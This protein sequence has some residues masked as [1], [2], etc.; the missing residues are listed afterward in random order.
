MSFYKYLKFKQ[1]ALFALSDSMPLTF[2]VAISMLAY[3]YGV[4]SQEDYFS[5]IIASMIDGLFL[6]ILIRKLYKWFDLKNIKS[7]KE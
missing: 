2:M 5:F 7:I 3:K 6:M 1:T 4:I